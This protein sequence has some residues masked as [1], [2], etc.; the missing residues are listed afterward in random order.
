MDAVFEIRDITDSPHD[1]IYYLQELV[2]RPPRD[3]RVIT[4]GDRPIAA[5]Y[6]KVI[7][8]I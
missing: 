5:M 6:Q 2:K 1:R 7:R 8:R 3:I 4:V